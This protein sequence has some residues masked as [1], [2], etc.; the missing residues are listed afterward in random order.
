MSSSPPIEDYES[1]DALG[2]AELVRKGDVQ[3]S[4]LL[5]AALLRVERYNPVINAVVIPMFEEARATL[6]GQLPD[7]PFRGV[8]FLL[9]DLHALYAGV[10]TT[11]GCRLFAGF[12]PDHD[13]ELVVR[14][15]QAGLVIF[16]PRQRRH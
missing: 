11:N 13:S 12:V 15:R 9:K 1:Y 3:P 4:E 10:R 16:G 7:G 5:D 8:P 2:L 6:A 14:Y